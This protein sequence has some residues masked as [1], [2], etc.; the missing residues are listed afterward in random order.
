MLA[1]DSGT[2]IVLTF[3]IGGTKLAAAVIDAAA[4]EIIAQT[5]ASYPSDEGVETTLVKGLHH[6]G[7]LQ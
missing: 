5:R 4:G 6:L 1:A 3:D 2:D 7:R